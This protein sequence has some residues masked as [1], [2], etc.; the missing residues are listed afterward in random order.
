MLTTQRGEVESALTLSCFLPLCCLFT[1]EGNVC[2]CVC[3][4]VQW[5]TDTE[6]ER[7]TASLSRLSPALMTVKWS[8]SL[9][10]LLS[11]STLDLSALSDV[12]LL[13]AGAGP[14]SRTGFLQNFVPAQEERPEDLREKC[15]VLLR[16]WFMQ[17]QPL[18]YQH[19]FR[20]LIYLKTSQ[21][22]FVPELD[23]RSESAV[24]PCFCSRTWN[25]LQMEI[26]INEWVIADRFEAFVKSESYWSLH[27]A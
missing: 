1:C 2:V 9:L 18:V 11:R 20:F 25:N 4:C 16:R 10:L 21:S 5:R 3:V 23:R 6:T 22:S 27:V 7:M 17:T 14:W 24:S 8:V 13:P 19:W 15:K 26:K 12:Y